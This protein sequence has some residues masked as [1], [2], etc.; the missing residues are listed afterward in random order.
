[1]TR[2]RQWF[3][4]AFPRDEKGAGSV[5]YVSLIACLAIT[6]GATISSLGSNVGSLYA[7]SSNALAGSSEMSVPEMVC[8]GEAC[9]RG[10]LRSR[11]R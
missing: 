7:D 9:T 10:P 4:H 6:V 11:E 8:N 1:M 5:E 3:A 2:S